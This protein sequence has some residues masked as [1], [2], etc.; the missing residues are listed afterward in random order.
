MDEARTLEAL[1]S[2]EDELDIEALMTVAAAGEGGAPLSDAEIESLMRE[3]FGLPTL[4]VE[5]A[6]RSAE[7][8]R[9]APRPS[10]DDCDDYDE[11]EWEIV[12][13][14][15]RYCQDAI[16]PATTEKRRATCVE[17]SFVRG[18]EDPRSGVSFHLACQ[19]LKTRPWVVQALIQHFWF[20]RGT[21]IA[22]LPF[23]ADELPEAVEHEATMH[24]WYEGAKIAKRV[25]MAPGAVALDVRQSID[26]TAKEFDRAL[27]RLVEEGIIGVRMNHLHVTSRPAT[28]R[29]ARQAV[30]WSNSFVGD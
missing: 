7:A 28:F 9:S 11:D 4:D 21:A 29:R 18:V 6:I 8:A 26:L 10:N 22:P 23:M 12:K 30:S 24:G 14:L 27:E 15:R 20:T 25:W 16:A 13:V 5:S 17:W 2:D 1:F 3:Q 19:M